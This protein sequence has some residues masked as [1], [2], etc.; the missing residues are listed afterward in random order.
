MKLNVRTITVG[1][2]WEQEHKATLSQKLQDF[3]ATATKRFEQQGVT[4]KTKRVA[5]APINKSKKSSLISALNV[6]QWI[7]DAC[8]SADVRW[9][10]VPVDATQSTNLEQD[11]LTAL[12]IVKR[13]SNIF[14]NFMAAKDGLINPAAAFYGA[15]LIKQVSRLNN[16]GFDNF[17]VGISANCKPNTPYFPFTYHVGNNGF[18]MALELANPILR[19]V[20]A[21]K[22]PNL[23]ELREQIIAQLAP[24]I[25]E[26]DL[27]ARELEQ[28]TGFEYRGIDL[29]LAPLPDEEHSVGRIVEA[30]GPTNFG[31]S[32]TLFIT[33]Y[34]KNIL[35]A[36]IEQTQMKAVGF[37]GVMYS[38]LEDAFL[39]K[40]NNVR[41][42]SIDSLISFACVCGCGVDMV[43]IPGNTL[44]TEIAS[45]IMDT[46]GQSTALNKPLGVRLLPIP[47]KFENEY[48]DFSH[49]FLYNSRIMEVRNRGCE[50]KLF[51][52]TNF[53][54]ESAL[55]PLQIDPQ[56]QNKMLKIKMNS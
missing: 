3:L 11:Q 17:R 34:L 29:S 24:A 51:D 25:K 28:E 56:L 38:L 27:L 10:C 26:V 53:V 7:S 16:N 22:Q 44:E 13:H 9:F 50:H 14:L 4:I 42:F 33:S 18:S 15:K 54:Y 30:L 21:P 19:I 52:T 41:N 32:G 37:N 12:E 47:M 39:C 40:N 43:P 49:D 35:N 1:L 31:T 46:A 55:S 8:Q 36:L 48:T 20:E 2:D 6:V 45:I 5:L 23:V